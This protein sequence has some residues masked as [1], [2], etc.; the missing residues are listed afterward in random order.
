MTVY[1]PDKQAK[2]SQ[3][4]YGRKDK[5]SNKSAPYFLTAWAKRFTN[6]HDTSFIESDTAKRDSSILHHT[7]A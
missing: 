2:S 6:S 4:V 5:C 3:R 7:V 1:V